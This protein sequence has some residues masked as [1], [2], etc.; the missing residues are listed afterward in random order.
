MPVPNSAC[1]RTS[2][3]GITGSKPSP[4]SFSS[5]QRTSASS[6]STSSPR[7]Y[8]KRLPDRRAPRSMSIRSPASSRW[9]LPVLPASPTSRMTVSSGAASAAGRFGSVASSAS[10]SCATAVCASDSA[11][12]RS[13]NVRICA[14]CSSVG[15]PCS[16][17]VA[18]FCSACS[19]SSCVVSS[20]QRASASSRR[21]SVASST[22]PRRASAA[23]TASGSRRISLRSST[24]AAPG[25]RYSPPVGAV[26]ELFVSSDWPASRVPVQWKPLASSPLPS[27]R[28]SV[29]AGA[30]VARDEVGDLSAPAR[31]RRCSP[32]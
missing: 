4:E 2:T 10:R 32:A 16:A 21:S 24:G 6:S 17:R 22:S 5:A 29:A 28:G 9:S 15:A 30:G 3:G 27:G 26:G 18:S 19:V 14:R 7:R 25:R 20:R 13:D 8:A 23:R 1:S 11:R 31:R 12:P